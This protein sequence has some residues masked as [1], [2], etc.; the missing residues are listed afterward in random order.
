ME[1][2]TVKQWRE[3]HGLTQEELADLLGVRAISISRWERGAQRPPGRL[4]ELA[5]ELLDQRLAR[6]ERDR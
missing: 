6:E 4:L 2:A 5:L 3:G 1:G